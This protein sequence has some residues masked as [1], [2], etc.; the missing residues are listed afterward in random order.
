MV[1]FGFI[2]SLL[3]SLAC[4]AAQTQDE[5]AE[6]D[7]A[8]QAEAAWDQIYQNLRSQP[9]SI[10]T[11]TLIAPANS[12]FQASASYRM[13]Q[14]ELLLHYNY[15]QKYALSAGS[16]CLTTKTPRWET[17]IG[18]YRFRF[19]RGIVSG[20]ASRSRPDSLFSLL[21]P[22]S[23]Q[24]FTPLGAVLALRHN[25][26]RATVFGSLQDREAKIDSEGL[27]RSLFKTR[28]G[29]LTT[30]RE[31]I[32][33][34]AAGIVRP[35][36]QLGAL[37]YWLRY[38]RDFASA[39]TE[40]SVWLASLYAAG[41]YQNLSLDAEAAWVNGTPG[42]LLSL[43][44]K[45]PNFEQNLSY[46]RN[47]S[48]GQLPYALTPGVLSSGN[49]RDEFNCD[50][51]LGLPLKTRLKLRY[52]V[53]SGSGFSGGALSRFMGSLAYSDRGSHLKLLFHNY[54]HEIISLVDSNYV[55]SDPRNWRFQLSGQ[56]H[57]L[58]QFYQRLDFT[59]TL[60]D[61]ADYSQ[62]TYRIN[63]GFAFEH[64]GLEVG[65]NYLAWQSA[66][67]IWLVDELNPYVL[68]PESAEDKLVEANLAWT[69]GAW[70]LGFQGQRSLLDGGS[71][72]LWLR[73][74]WSCPG[75]SADS[76]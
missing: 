50:L 44:Y 20:S 21:E 16:F 71:Y 49:G 31:E 61:K 63:F 45:L 4:L 58:P 25:S 72:R 32:L 5:L 7:Y 34:A 68:L 75:R 28:G 42:A 11:R 62:N 64:N 30:T 13:S 10:A 74:G 38:D 40:S 59:Y 69:S 29:A 17:A 6:L 26:L 41:R 60:K 52:T 67:E 14:A 53:N 23:P 33:G 15:R 24:N 48:R 8:A 66:E 56:Y 22:L 47:C 54:D 39:E 18:S 65:L 51:S 36:F 1:K 9:L 73:C 43:G 12:Q 70:R 57:F 76:A 35:R 3:F 37:A 2:L 46:A 19:G 55:S 27:I